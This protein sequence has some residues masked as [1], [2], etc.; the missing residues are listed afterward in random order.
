MG[1]K[2]NIESEACG[3]RCTGFDGKL[4]NGQNAWKKLESVVKEIPC[5][6]C[7]DDGLKRLSGMHDMVNLGL[8][9]QKKPFDA[10]NFKKFKDDLDCVYAKCKA[11]GDCL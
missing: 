3:F 10:K 11:R 9:E 1:I 7:R 8:G 2:C 4:A 5:E 6:S